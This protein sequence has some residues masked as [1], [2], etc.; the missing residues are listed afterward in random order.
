MIDNAEA[1]AETAPEVQPDAANEPENAQAA[2]QVIPLP[3]R[4]ASP[5]P[6]RSL[7]QQQ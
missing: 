5:Q 6:P 2:P 4:I 7:P 1:P 3:S